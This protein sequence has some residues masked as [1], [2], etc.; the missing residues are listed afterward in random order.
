M[1]TLLFV[2][3]PLGLLVWSGCS[4]SDSSG[5]L[6]SETRR[7]N[8]PS[9]TAPAVGAPCTVQFRRDLLGTH[10]NLPVDPLTNGI[11]GARTSVSGKL[12]RVD[13]D[14]IVLQRKQG[15]LWIPRRNVLL[16]DIQQT[17]G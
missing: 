9:L 4:A 15:Q 7:P 2:L 16:L 12:L 8:V 14:W 10:S 1:R 11:N 13:A 6:A 5:T 17:G 3:L